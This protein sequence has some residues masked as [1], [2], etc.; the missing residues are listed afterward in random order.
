MNGRSYLTHGVVHS[1]PMRSRV[2]IIGSILQEVRLSS[3]GMRKTR[4]M[5]RCNLSFKQVKN[6]LLLLV[7]KKFVSLTVV[8]DDC[9]AR[10][11]V[12]GITRE[13]LDFLKAYDELKN[14]LKEDR[15][16]R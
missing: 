16:A 4:L 7:E 1:A 6:Y 10:V 14:R 9:A 15:L 2:E 12:Y 5:Y 11:E 8:V 13:G 3:G